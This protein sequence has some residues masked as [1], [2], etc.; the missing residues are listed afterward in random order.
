VILKGLSGDSLR[1]DE[2]MRTKWI[3]G[4][5]VVF[6]SISLFA[7]YS[8]F[9]E[10]MGNIEKGENLFVSK[11]AFCHHTDKKDTKVGP[12]LREIFK[13][14]LLP[15][16]KKDVTRENIRSQIKTPLAKMPAFPD[17]SEQDIRDI[18]AYL[19]VL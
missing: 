6:L 3:L 7:G 15:A 17:L 4:G 18:I 14:K 8:S 13:G 16:S 9:G 12:G 1:E 11:C 5:L 2:G 19:R 10:G